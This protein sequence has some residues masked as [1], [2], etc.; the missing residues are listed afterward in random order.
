[1]RNLSEM[2][3]LL[4]IANMLLD[5]TLTAAKEEEESK[6]TLAATYKITNIRTPCQFLGI[7]IHYENDGSIALGQRVFIDSVLK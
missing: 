2:L 5:F 4:Y 7:E 3:L 6:Q 1:M